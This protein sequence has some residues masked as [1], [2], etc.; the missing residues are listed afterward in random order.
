MRRF[1]A[2]GCSWIT[3]ARW[4]P[5]EL[6]QLRA[7]LVP[8][9]REAVDEDDGQRLAL[10]DPVQRTPLT[11]AKPSRQLIRGRTG[12][13]RCRGRETGV[14]ASPVSTTRPRYITAIT[15]LMWATAARSCAMNR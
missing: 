5:A 11:S 7:P 1:T 3:M 6:R 14:R 15:W 4:S 9:L 10:A 12:G 2:A 13:R 8:D